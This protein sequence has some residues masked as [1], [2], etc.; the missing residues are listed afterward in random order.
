MAKLSREQVKFLKS[1]E[2]CR[3]ATV[4]KDGMPQVTPVIYALD[5]DAFVIAVDY[6]TK[7]LANLRENPKAS[8]VVDE[9]GNGNKAI[10][11]QGRCVILERGPEY[12]RLLH[13]LF[14]RFEYYRNNPW[15]EGE[16]PILR[17]VPVKIVAWGLGK[18]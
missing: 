14:E 6:G 10:M 7:K 8:L 9:Y 16:S 2:V 18:G 12:L 5:G 13:I 11:I 4:S 3:L 1:S 17:I 15:G